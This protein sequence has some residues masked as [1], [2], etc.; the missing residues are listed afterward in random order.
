[1]QVDLGAVRVNNSAVRDKLITSAS[2]LV[3]RLLR[4]LQTRPR[5]IVAAAAKQYRDIQGQLL[6][7]HATVEDIAA[8]RELITNLPFKLKEIIAEVELAAPWYT[9]FFLTD[10]QPASCFAPGELP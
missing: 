2:D 9:T 3:S 5:E 8:R 1:L 4:V 10:I 7:G 6:Q